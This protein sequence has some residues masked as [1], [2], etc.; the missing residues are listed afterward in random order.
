MFE[1]IPAIDILG[2][3]AVRLTKGDYNQ[4]TVYHDYPEEMARSFELAGAST[5]HLVDLDGARIGH[6]INMQII[7]KIR[8][9]VRCRLEL[10]GGLRTADDVARV[11]DLGIERVILGSVA[12]KNRPLTEQ[13]VKQYGRRIVIGIDALNGFV[14]TEGWLKSSKVTVEALAKEMEAIGVQTII[15]TDISC[16]GM[17]A[18]PNLAAYKAI[19]PKTAM[20]VIASG[21][22]SGLK[23]IRALRAIPALAGVV[24]GKAIYEKKIKLKELFGE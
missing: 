1:A 11:L 2:G 3:K 20:A 23:D 12:L 7:E 8:L 13:L 9:A 21:G 17:L 18:G 16:D 5:I 22:I 15:Y 14:A 4:V 10:G 24:V 6:P 19:V